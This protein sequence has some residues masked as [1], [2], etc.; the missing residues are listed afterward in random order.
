MFMMINNNKP[1]LRCR[2]EWRVPSSRRPFWA[3]DRH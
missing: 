2:P 1:I 3:P